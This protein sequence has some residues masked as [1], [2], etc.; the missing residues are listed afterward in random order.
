[1]LKKEDWMDIREQLEKGFYQKDIANRLGVHPKTVSRA[2][3]RQGAPLGVRPN[4]HKSKLDEFK[5]FVDELLR[6]GVWN[7]KVILMKCRE[8]GYTGSYSVV[9]DYIHPKRPMRESKA[10]VRY[11]T[12]PGHQMQNDWGAVTVQVSGSPRKVHFTVNT[13]G[14]SRRFHFWCAQKEDAEHTYEGII[15]A[16]EYFGGVPRE[17]LVDNQKSL[18]ITTISVMP[19]TSTS[20]SSILPVT[21][22]SRPGPAARTGPGPRARTSVWWDTSRGTSSSGTGASTASST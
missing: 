19:C 20:G 18:V 4:A 14:Y 16:F 6:E 11:E 22:G 1:M 13:L 17:V 8:R 12:E 5:P 21:T 2:L 3:A 9:R 10:T 7:A 15:R